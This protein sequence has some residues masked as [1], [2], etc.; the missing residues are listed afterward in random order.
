MAA[1]Y[2]LVI[3]FRNFLYSRGLLKSYSITQGGL[4]TTDRTQATIPV[5]SVGNITVGGTG[6]TPMVIWLCQW[7]RS[8]D[9]NCTVLTRG[10]KAGSETKTDEPAVLAKNLPGT[11]VVVN[12][13][14]LEGALEAVKRHRAQVLV[15]DDGFQHR[16]LHRE[17]DIVMIDATQPFGFGKM[18]PAGL[19]RE[20]ITSL[21]RAQAA[22]ITRCDQVSEDRSEEIIKNINPNI[23]IA[24]AVHQP[25]CVMAGDKQIPVGQLKGRKVYAFCGIANP[26]AFFATIKS[27]ADEVVGTKICD[28]H[29]KY[30]AGDVGE[31]FDEAQRAE[32]EFI[33]T[34]E[35]DYNKID[36]SAT[37]KKG[38]VLA[39]VAVRMQLLSGEE[40]ITQLI[41]RSFAGRIPRKRTV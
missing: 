12:P 23:V 17:I 26:E 32:A 20:P 6:K 38:T 30:T 37:A 5:I 3:A 41:E 16:R 28:D 22:V 33:L 14:R 21:K 8:K 25:V 4:I 11:A 36:L 9:I 40:Q 31:I 2:G 39:F 35:K 24:K 19:L 18:L 15:M 7:L 1:F 10:Y 34:T 13:D 27:L 29:H